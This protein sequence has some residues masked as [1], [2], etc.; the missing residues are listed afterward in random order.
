MAMQHK[1]ICKQGSAAAAALV[2]SASISGGAYAAEG[3]GSSYLQGTY[4]DFAAAVVPAP[5]AYLRNDFILYDAGIGARPVAGSLDPG[6]DQKLW[7]DRLTL[8]AYSATGFWGGKVGVEVQIPYMADLTVA[9]NA[10]GPPFDTLGSP[11]DSGLG[12]PIVKPQLVWAA[13]P[14]YTKLSLG[15][16]MAAGSYDSTKVV[17]AGRHYWSFDPSVTYTY[18]NDSGWD[19]ST[20]LGYM[21]NLENN[22]PGPNYTTGDELHLDALFGKHFGEHFALGVAAYYY[23]Q[24]TDDDGP[25][26]S[27]PLEA[28]Y[29]SQGWG[30]GP[31][32]SFGS[33][34]FSV[35]GKWLYDDHA[36][37]RLKGDLY[38]LS[39]VARFDTGRPAPAPVPVA[40]PPVARVEPP[41]PPPPP[42][43]ADAD[44]DGV[45]DLKDKCPATPRGQRVDVN[46]C[47][48]DFTVQVN[49]KSNSTEISGADAI[50]L[51][52]LAD[53]VRQ[54][55]T[56]TG[57]LGG[58][59][60]S[61]GPEAFN[62]DLSRRR[63]LAV[64]D[65]LSSRG[66]NVTQLAVEGHGESDP[67]ADNT[68]VEGRAQ[69]RRV[70]LSRTNCTVN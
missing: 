7:M 18:L 6:F 33:K 57:E 34:N 70:V 9:Q 48:C 25:I 27:P 62:L 53:Q 28:G 10:G 43:P 44:G 2:V 63:A 21:I 39:F 69:N 20:T 4:G 64:R 12:D 31:A 30:Y 60:D 59:T 15:I 50:L 66:I 58:H 14:H 22:I 29:P 55:P 51:D 23:D 5:G 40:P 13:G 11:H 16:V 32:F 49:F 56:I 52:S 24:M 38:M 47:S 26:A 41:P 61:Q 37:N 35:V 8:G 36:E 68:T 67:V 19:L 54:L 46:G 17:S 1:R 45:N 65:Y 42:P 3:G